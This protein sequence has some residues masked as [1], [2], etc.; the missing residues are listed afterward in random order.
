M[1]EHYSEAAVNV[2]LQQMEEFVDSQSL[3]WLASQ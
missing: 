3:F 2:K 1:E